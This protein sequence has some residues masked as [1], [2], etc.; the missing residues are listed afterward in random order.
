[1]LVEGLAHAARGK[2]VFRCEN[3]RGTSPRNRLTCEQQGFGKVRP[4]KIDVVHRGQHGSLLAVPA[5][6]QIEQVGR[7]LG[8]DRIERLVQHDHAGVLQKQAREQ[9]ALHLPAGKGRD[10][11]ILEAGESDGGDCLLDPC[12]GRAIKAA[13]QAGPPPQPHRHH[14]VDIDRECAVDLGG[15]RQVSDILCG[16]IAALDAARQRLDQADDAFEQRRLAC[17]VRTDDRDQRA[18]FDRA[19]EMM[20]GRMPVI[21]EREVAELQRRRHR[22]IPSSPRPPPPTAARS[23]R[24]RP[25]GAPGSTSAEWTAT[26]PPAGVPDRGDDGGA[27]GGRASA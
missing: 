8:V 4:H 7:G 21:A 12:P 3:G 19:V 14:V 25:P 10:R 20:H 13:E 9:H 18:G 6:H 17:S 22:F 27:A 15:L 5:L 11:A 16:K 2:Q 24:R 23:R 26:P 1:M